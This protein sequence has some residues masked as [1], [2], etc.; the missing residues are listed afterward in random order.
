[1]TAKA[2][3]VRQAVELGLTCTALCRRL[4]QPAQ[5]RQNITN[6]DD[7]EVLDDSAFRLSLSVGVDVEVSQASWDGI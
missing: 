3:Y 2:Y 5:M 6:L 1:M 4:V 7:E